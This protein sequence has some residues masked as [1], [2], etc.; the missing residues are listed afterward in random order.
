MRA[1]VGTALLASALL[2]SACAEQQVLV[3]QGRPAQTA[4][5]CEAAYREARQRGGYTP[6]PSTGAGL[7]GAALGRGIA[8]G[9]IDSSYRSCLARVA[10]T[11]PDATVVA[12]PAT[13][14]VTT[15]TKVRRTAPVAVVR[16]PVRAPACYPGAPV[17]IGGTGYCTGQP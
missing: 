2:L 17:L 6:A 11:A 3:Y 9:I 13:T 4:L 16:T 8:R 7:A 14:T 1:R 15:V 5:E 12:V 10:G